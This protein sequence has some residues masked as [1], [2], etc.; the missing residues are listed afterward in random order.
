MVEL[1]VSFL[2]DEISVF[3]LFSYLSTRTILSTLT[4]L[5]LVLIFGE[6]FIRLISSF[7]YNQTFDGRAPER[8]MVKHGTPTMGG[9]L[10]VSS[11]LISGILWGN[12]FDKYLILGL[13][14]I[15][16]FAIIGF[17]D[18][19]KKVKIESS[20]GLSS[21]EKIFFQSILAGVISISLFM[22]AVD[23]NELIYIVPFFKNVALDLGIFFIFISMFI[24]VGSSN[25]VN[26]TDGLDGLAILPVIIITSALGIIAWAA[27]NVIASDYL[28]IPYVEGTG[29]LLVLCGALIGAGIGFLWFNTYPAQIFMGDVGSLSMGAFIAYIAIVVRHEIV[30]AVMSAVFVMEALSVIIQVGSFKIRKKRV[31]K[32]APIH[33]HFELSGWKEPKIIVRFWILTF[34][35][36]LVGLSLLKIR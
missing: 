31:F 33:H 23:K 29:E 13:I 22:L 5:L 7:Q 35:F 14:C 24:I 1:L 32:M 4:S 17:I 11:V 20:K 19:Y 27:G 28:Y 3:N 36:V 12:L 2:F 18:D 8:H 21:I 15:V 30:F 9:I 16:G 26:L 34:I 10:I 25:A 6:G